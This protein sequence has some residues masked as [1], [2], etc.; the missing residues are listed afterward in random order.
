M[1]YTNNYKFEKPDQDDAYDIGNENDSMDLIDEALKNTVDNDSRGNWLS[2]IISYE[3]GHEKE[4]RSSEY[5]YTIE[6]P[7][8]V[9]WTRHWFELKNKMNQLIQDNRIYFGPAPDYKMV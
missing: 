1:Q 2:E 6:S 4:D 9:K 3:W 7:S 5:Y 8:G